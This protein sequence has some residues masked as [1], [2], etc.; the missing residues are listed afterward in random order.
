[1]L[2]EFI[3]R[4]KR[5]GEIEHFVGRRYGDFVKMYK[6]LRTE[7]P[8]RVLPQLPKKNKQSSTASNLMNSIRG[9]DDSDASSIS[10]VSTISTFQ[11]DGPVGPASIAGST[12]N[13]LSSKRDHRRST[14]AVSVGRS[15]LPSPR[16]SVDGR[17]EASSTDGVSSISPISK[18]DSFRDVY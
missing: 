4:V 2:Q 5:K 18:A 7:L 13:L 10:S 8:G 11:T 3:L 6:R 15:P 17:P 9:G 14:S 16:P 1:V 12:R